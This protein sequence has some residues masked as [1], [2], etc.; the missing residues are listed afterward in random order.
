[1]LRILT[2]NNNKRTNIYNI[3]ITFTLIEIARMISRVRLV[4]GFVF[5]IDSEFFLSLMRCEQRVDSPSQY[6]LYY[7][8]I[9]IILVIACYAQTL[10]CQLNSNIV[11]HRIYIIV[12]LFRRFHHESRQYL[13][14][15]IHVTEFRW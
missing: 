10:I 11:L 15:S 7:I 9:H 12:S 3:H 4:W 5:G 13:C 8:H 1:M 6:R 14:A 2:R